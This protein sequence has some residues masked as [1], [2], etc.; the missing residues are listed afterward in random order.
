MILELGCIYFVRPLVFKPYKN[1]NT[2][3]EYIPCFAC[4][5]KSLNIEGEVHEYM[6]ASPGCWEMFNE[7]LAREYSDL[8]YWR[9]H[10]FTVDAYACQHVGKKEDRRALNSVNIHLVSLHGIFKK[11]LSQSEAPKLKEKFSQFH[12]GK[13]TLEWLEPPSFG[14]LTIF[15]LWDNDDVNLHYELAENWARSVWE[16]WRPQHEKIDELIRQIN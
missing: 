1:Q 10:H 5:A 7:V 2:M 8:R 15:E 11:G 6:L 12:K 4:G 3:Q 14:P 13:N 9:A 16:A